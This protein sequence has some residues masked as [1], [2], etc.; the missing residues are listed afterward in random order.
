VPFSKAR[1]R[2]DERGQNEDLRGL[3]QAVIVIVG[4]SAWTHRQSPKMAKIK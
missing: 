2:E 3:D 4:M 1:T